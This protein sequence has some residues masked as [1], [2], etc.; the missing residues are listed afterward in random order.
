MLPSQERGGA[1]SLIKIIFDV[2]T[3]A[4]ILKT[5]EGKVAIFVPA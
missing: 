5:S 3:E 2:L 4:S 1:S